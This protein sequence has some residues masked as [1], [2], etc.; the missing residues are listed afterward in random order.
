MQFC[1]PLHDEMIRIVAP[2]D[3]DFCQV[4]AAFGWSDV[5]LMA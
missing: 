1:H 2:L 5:D 3:T 4:M